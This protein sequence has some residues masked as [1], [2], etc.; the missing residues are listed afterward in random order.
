MDIPGNHL[1]FTLP[2]Y[3]MAVTRVDVEISA[4]QLRQPLQVRGRHDRILTPAQHQNRAAD[5][6][7][8]EVDVTVQ[9]VADQINGLGNHAPGKIHRS[10]EHTSKL[11]SRLHL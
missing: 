3:P 5:A 7:R 2:Q 9:E 6:I 1:P 8:M 10:E 11:Q 4:E